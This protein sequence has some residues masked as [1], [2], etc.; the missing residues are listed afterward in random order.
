[1]SVISVMKSLLQSY[2][3]F[4][5]SCLSNRQFVSLNHL[6]SLP[7]SKNQSDARHSARYNENTPN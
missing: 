5:L 2:Y 4:K 6:Y 1:L 7:N 3:T